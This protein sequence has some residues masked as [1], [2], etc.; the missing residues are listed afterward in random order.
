MDPIL[1]YRAYTWESRVLPLISRFKLIMDKKNI[2]DV[3]QKL[4]KMLA[5]RFVRVYFLQIS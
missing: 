3:E 5:R 4:R 2:N 1:I